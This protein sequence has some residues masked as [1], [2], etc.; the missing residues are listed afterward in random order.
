MSL[1]L[2]V[3]D[4][5]LEQNGSLENL[6]VSKSLSAAGRGWGEGCNGMKAN[7]ISLGCLFDAIQTQLQTPTHTHTHTASQVHPYTQEDK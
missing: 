7:I 6:K 1:T 5:F 3:C 4:S 2:S